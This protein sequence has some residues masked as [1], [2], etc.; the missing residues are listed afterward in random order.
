MRF[1]IKEI[2]KKK[3]K[4]KPR[5]VHKAWEVGDTKIETKFAWVF[6]KINKKTKV[7]LEKYEQHFQFKELKYRIPMPGMCTH[8]LSNK[9]S[10]ISWDTNYH[11][12]KYQTYT[13]LEW[14]KTK[15]QLIN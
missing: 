8:P 10:S 15:R 4:I 6:T 7:W 14:V 3:K 13:K 2:E 12:T 11:F 1:D 5:K 9:S